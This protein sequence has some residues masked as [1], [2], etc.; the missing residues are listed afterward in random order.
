MIV[1]SPLGRCTKEEDQQVQSGN[2]E[3][4]DDDSEGGVGVG[5]IVGVGDVGDVGD[6]VGVGDEGISTAPV[7]SEVM[8]ASR[9]SPLTH[10]TQITQQLF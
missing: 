3:E 10:P 2:E 8:L 5:D 1:S 7:S 6:I 4:H 9:K